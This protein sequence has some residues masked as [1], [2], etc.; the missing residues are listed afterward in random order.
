[1]C[2]VWLETHQWKPCL[3]V[4]MASDTNNVPPSTTLAQ[5]EFFAPLWADVRFHWIITVVKVLLGV[6]LYPKFPQ[7][8]HTCNHIWACVTKSV[9]H[10]WM[11]A[12]SGDYSGTNS[13]LCTN[14]R[15]T[16]SVRSA[17]TTDLCVHHYHCHSGIACL[18]RCIFIEW[19]VGSLSHTFSSVIFLQRHYN[20]TA[21][22]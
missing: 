3:G 12:S 2:F 16:W 11:N 5:V 18:F 22:H 21:F 14:K 20:A 17:S 8:C 19:G 1:M 6:R 13:E 7:C 10:S 15:Q 4:P 9:A